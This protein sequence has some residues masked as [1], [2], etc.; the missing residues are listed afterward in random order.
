MSTLFQVGN[1]FG[2]SVARVLLFNTRG[3]LLATMEKPDFLTTKGER[4]IKSAVINVESLEWHYRDILRGA[5]AWTGLPGDMPNGFIDSDALWYNG[6]FAIKKVR[7]M[8]LCGF[9]CEPVMLDIYGRPVK[10]LARP[11]GWPADGTRMS[12]SAVI[13]ASIFSE[14]DTPV[15]WLQASYRTRCLPYLQ[16]MARALQ[17]LGNNIT[18]LNHPVL[19]SGVASGQVGDNI[20]SILLK[21]EIEEGSTFIPIVRPDLTG[22]EAIDLGVTDNTQ[23]LASIIDWC[24]AR[25]LEILGVST[26]V[27]KSSGIT[28]METASGMGGMGCLN[29]SALR[30]REM[31]AD[32]A[33]AVLGT[34]ITVKRAQIIEDIVDGDE[35]NENV[36]DNK[37]L[38]GESEGSDGVAIQAD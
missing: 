4:R 32:K 21:T 36:D 30:I 22:L 1:R 29:D 33:N 37:H 34:D 13:D 16:I 28:T 27:E 17:A 35:D 38:A 12:G 5:F 6:G 23:N 18:A 14:S 8:G 25:I 2:C 11:Y 9:P 7:S 19:I 31:W 24:D 3:A 15:L 26:G 20:A 10:W